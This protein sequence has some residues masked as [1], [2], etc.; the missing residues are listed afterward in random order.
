MDTLSFLQDSARVITAAL[1]E[2]MFQQKQSEEVRV[3][4]AWLG[5]PK[6]GG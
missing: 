2:G 3:C 4:R 1:R 5:D 6:T